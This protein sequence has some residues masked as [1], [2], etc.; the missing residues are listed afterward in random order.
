LSVLADINQ[1]QKYLQEKQYRVIE[2]GIKFGTIGVLLPESG[3]IEITMAR[4]EGIYKS[5]R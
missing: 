4:K 1:V 2:I 5:S 3:L